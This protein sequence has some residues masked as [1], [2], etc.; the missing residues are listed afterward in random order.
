M[1]FPGDR[2][3]DG[4]QYAWRARATDSKLTSP[5]TAWCYFRVDRTPPTA[6]VTTDAS[7][8]KVG[9]EATF[10]LKGA[11]TGSEIACARWRTT[12]TES[13]GWRCSDEATDAHVVRL[14]DGALDIKV[15]PADWGSQAVYLSS[16]AVLR[17]LGRR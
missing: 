13:V 3:A 1:Y 15:K 14:T 5:Y 16:C 8:K 6:E 2:F 11:D 10:T 12:P 9:E 17:P 7:P 4:G